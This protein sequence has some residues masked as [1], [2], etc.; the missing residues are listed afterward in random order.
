V[1]NV[2]SRVGHDWPVPDP[3]A[4]LLAFGL[5]SGKCQDGLKALDMA[6]WW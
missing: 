4:I 1:D 6:R 5:G 3:D 2:H